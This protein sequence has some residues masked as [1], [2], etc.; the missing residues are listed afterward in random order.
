MNPDSRPPLWERQPHETARAFHAF[1]LYLNQEPGKRN[2]LDAYLADKGM[3][4]ETPASPK[5][6]AGHW[7]Y[8]YAARNPQGE[9]DSRFIPWP[10]RAAAW[11][12]YLAAKARQEAEAKHMADIAEY[13]ETMSKL[14]QANMQNAIM[15]IQIAGGSLES[16]LTKIKADQESQLKPNQIPSWLRAANDTIE[17]TTDAWAQAL[18]IDQ[19]IQ[20]IEE[21]GP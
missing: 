3:T 18:A 12:D 9:K 13:R 16:M 1:L 8:W 11:D 6:P 2:L 5:R 21:G 20:A 15:V 19:L 4:R 10:E 14:A 7:T 17:K